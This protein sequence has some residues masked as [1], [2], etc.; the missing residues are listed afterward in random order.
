[1]SEDKGKAAGCLQTVSAMVLSILALLLGIAFLG[2]MFSGGKPLPI[3]PAPSV[4]SNN[5]SGQKQLPSC[6]DLMRKARDEHIT[7]PSTECSML[8]LDNVTIDP[9]KDSTGGP[10]G[11][12][13]TCDQMNQMI[14]DISGDQK[15]SGQPC[16]IYHDKLYPDAN[17]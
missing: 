9:L 13:L 4:S 3:R 16:Y 6:V 17:K 7:I 2:N 8:S 1:M 11:P 10:I 14:R 12:G 15:M 5:D